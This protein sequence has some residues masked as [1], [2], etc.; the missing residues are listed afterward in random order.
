MTYRL[1]C[2]LYC[3]LQISVLDGLLAFGYCCSSTG[4][5]YWFFIRLSHHVPSQTFTCLVC[6]LNLHVYHDHHAVSAALSGAVGALCTRPRKENLQVKGATIT[7]SC[8]AL[9]VQH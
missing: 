5:M 1:W 8:Q 7:V 3:S 4:F 9:P 2:L 6:G